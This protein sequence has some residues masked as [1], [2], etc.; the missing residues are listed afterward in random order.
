MYSA[1]LPNGYRGSPGQAYQCLIESTTHQGYTIQQDYPSRYNGQSYEQVGGPNEGHR[2]VRREFQEY[3]DKSHI[4]LGNKGP[5]SP[6]AKSYTTETLT[7]SSPHSCNLP[8]T[9]L[10]NAGCLYSPALQFSNSEGAPTQ[11]GQPVYEGRSADRAVPD[12]VQGIYN[13]ISLPLSSPGRNSGLKNLEIP[14]RQ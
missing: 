7:V 1:N 8:N 4:P 6:R 11:F 14:N 12:K 2:P 3:Q 9:V 13:D 10:E 5:F